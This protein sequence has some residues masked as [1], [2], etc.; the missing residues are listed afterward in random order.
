MKSNMGR[1]SL[2]LNTV[3]IAAVIGA[4]GLSSS[5]FAE[6]ITVEQIGDENVTHHVTAD[7]QK[8]PPPAVAAPLPPAVLSGGLM[9]AGNFVLARLWKRKLV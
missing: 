2:F 3:R 7:D 1:S 8:L 4:L 5:A 6:A 9:L